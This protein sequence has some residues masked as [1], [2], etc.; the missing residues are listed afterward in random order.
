MEELLRFKKLYA[1]LS[2]IFLLNLLLW[3]GSRYERA[4]WDNI[5]PAP[6]QEAV[7]AMTLGDPQLAYRI[8]GIMLQNFGETGGRSTVFQDYNYQHLGDW[9]LLE[10]FLEPR[11][12]FVP[13]LAAYYF[14][15]SNVKED[16]NYVVDYLAKAGKY[17]MPNKWRWLAQAIFIARFQQ[18]EKEKA[19]EMAYDLA[20]IDYPGM[21][22]WSKQMPAFILADL[23]NKEAA[24]VFLM[25]LLQDGVQKFHP[26]EVNFMRGY[27]CEKVL[28]SNEARLNPVCQ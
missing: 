6:S 1:I 12:D 19:L 22:G 15:A 14:G 2:F 20:R 8:L 17:D 5:P 4:A 28:S 21:P 16:L 3:S 7:S 25:Q 9:F 27:I 18:E 26:A 11:S 10:H 24:Y 23:G 13:F